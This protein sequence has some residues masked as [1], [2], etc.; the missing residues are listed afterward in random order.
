[1][2]PQRL[3][4]LTAGW[5]D[6]VNL[7]LDREADPSELIALTESSVDPEHRKVEILWRVAQPP[8]KPRRL[9]PPKMAKQRTSIYPDVSPTGYPLAQM[10]R[11]RIQEAR[12]EKRAGHNPKGL[13][14]PAVQRRLVV[15]RELPQGPLREVS[16]GRR[17]EVHRPGQPLRRWNQ[18]GALLGTHLAQPPAHVLHSRP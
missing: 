18:A 8:G 17:L 4:H 10:M 7:S 11:R 1:V 5:R 2:Q 13:L 3:S 6:Q 14:F 16:P 9:A 12:R 15:D